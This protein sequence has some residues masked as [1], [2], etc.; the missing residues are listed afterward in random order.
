MQIKAP[1]GQ[2]ANDVD[3]QRFYQQPQNSY[4]SWHYTFFSS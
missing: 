1:G 4:K 2:W 3:Q